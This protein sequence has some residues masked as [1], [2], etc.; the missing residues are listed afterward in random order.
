[1][2]GEDWQVEYAAG[3]LA[4]VAA[5]KMRFYLHDSIRLGNMEL[6]DLDRTIGE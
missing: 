4:Q 1:M 3:K 2:R 6:F 5:A